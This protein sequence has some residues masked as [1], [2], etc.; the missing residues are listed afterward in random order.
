MT[1]ASFDAAVRA[2]LTGDATFAS[3]VG[4]LLGG[5]T[6]GVLESNLPIE[7]IPSS[8]F[9]AWVVEQGDGLLAPIV[10]D[11]GGGGL[12][13]GLSEQQFSS[14]LEIALVWKEQDRATA[15]NQRTALPT[16]VARLLMRNPKPGGAD[17]WL[18]SWVPDRGGLHPV[19]VWRATVRGEYITTRA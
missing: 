13:I 1:A 16:L 5:A 6:V 7:S 17:A 11:G 2:L 3:Q 4:T 18:E 14:T 8:M 15:R 12:V 9:P 10:N 19:Q